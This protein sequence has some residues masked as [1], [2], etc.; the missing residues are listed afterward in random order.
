M[1]DSAATINLL[2]G[3]YIHIYY[4]YIYIYKVCRHRLSAA[5]SQK[6]LTAVLI[7]R[8]ELT[9]CFSQHVIHHHLV[10]FAQLKATLWASKY[11]GA[12]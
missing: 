6:S 1:L 5:L 7:T 8:E 11:F 12:E 4:I 9:E 3:S 10:V 2:R